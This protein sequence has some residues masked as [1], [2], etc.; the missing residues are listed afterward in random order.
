MAIYKPLSVRL[1][2]TKQNGLIILWILI[3]FSFIIA[4]PTLYHF[5]L[6]THPR[7]NQSIVCK[8]VYNTPVDVIVSI[9]FMCIF[10]EV[11][12]E[13]TI[14]AC[15][16]VLG[17]KIYKLSRL[18]KHLRVEFTKSYPVSKKLS[19]PIFSSARFKIMKLTKQKRTVSSKIVSSGELRLARSISILATLE[20]IITLLVV[21][22][23]IVLAHSEFLGCSNELISQLFSAGILLNDLM[24]FIRLWNIYIYYLTIPTFKSEIN[25]IFRNVLTPTSSRR[26]TM[27][28]H[29][30]NIDF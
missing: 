25:R 28:Q 15:V 16:M 10:C 9:V 18:R 21:F 24:I 3:L 12:P 14:L 17:F 26:P 8:G 20:L 4:T 19:N 11:F 30:S 7:S 6:Q 29:T 27:D 13:I 23:W 5:K 2:A 22:I 1:F